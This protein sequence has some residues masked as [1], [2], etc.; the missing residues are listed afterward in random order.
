MS[1]ARPRVT[2]A[3]YLSLDTIVCPYGTFED[4]PGGALYAA[5]GARAA[6]ARVRLRASVCEDFPALWLDALATVGIDLEGLESAPGATRRARLEDREATHAQATRRASPHHEDP[7]WWARTR[8]L[9][10]APCRAPAD[11]VVITAMPA[12]CLV[13]HAEAAHSLGARVVADTSEA[14]AR[15]EAEALLA[16]LPR[17]DLFAPSREEVHLLLPG[18][19]DEAARHALDARCPQIVHKRGPDGMW[20]STAGL[21]VY[22]EPSHAREIADSTG[23]G[24]AAV[25]ALAAGLARDLPV[26]D[27]LREASAIAACAAGMVGPLGL[28]LDLERSRGP[29]PGPRAQGSAKPATRASR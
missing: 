27:L 5:L 22:H 13:R 17:L 28:G 15:L 29:E 12:D 21:P 24:D 4:V 18:L 8:A 20:W 16:A 9:A 10:P 14:Y 3:G 23:A 25:G 26:T 19:D 2:V 11:V 1:D 6:G 7:E